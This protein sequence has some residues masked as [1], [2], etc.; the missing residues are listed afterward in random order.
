M[1]DERLGRLELG[2]SVIDAQRADRDA[3]QP[4]AIG[5]SERLDQGAHVGA[6][7]ALDL[8]ARAL[9]VGGR[10]ARRGGSSPR[11]RR[12]DLLAAMG[13]L[14]EALALDPDGG[15]HRHALL[16]VPV[17]ELE[18]V[19]DAAGVRQLAVG[20]RGRRAP[21]EP[22]RR[23]IGL[24][25]PEQVALQARRRRPAAPSSS[26]VANGSSVP[27]W[28]PL[29]PRSRRTCSTTSCDVTPA[30]LSTSRIEAAA[31]RARAKAAPGPRR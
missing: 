7:R 27:A 15:R 24:R 19:R 14:V 11:A 10:A 29:T 26:P 22:R 18:A 17:G 4:L 28:P 2:A 5:V 13:A 31:G 25:Q 9:V 16:I 12:L 30:G 20:V 1:N 6:A 21:A 3:P 23:A 8:I